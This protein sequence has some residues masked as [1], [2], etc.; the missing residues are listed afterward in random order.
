MVYVCELDHLFH[1]SASQCNSGT[2]I[3]Q[4]F[5]ANAFPVATNH[6]TSDLQTKIMT[7]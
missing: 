4:I 5:V 7:V 2:A 3:W 1:P 6:K